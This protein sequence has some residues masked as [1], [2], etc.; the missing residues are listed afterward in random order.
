MEDKVVMLNKKTP[1]PRLHDREYARLDP[2]TMGIE[3][4]GRLS[5]DV[6]TLLL[7]SL[8]CVKRQVGATSWSDLLEAGRDVGQA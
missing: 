2:S 1:H 5:Q 3:H 7:D 6:Q 8:A 4:H